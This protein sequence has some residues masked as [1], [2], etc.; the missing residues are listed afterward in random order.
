MDARAFRLDD[1]S[2]PYRPVHQTGPRGSRVSPTNSQQWSLAVLDRRSL[3]ISA[4]R[5]SAARRTRP[6]SGELEPALFE[7][8]EDRASAQ[9]LRGENVDDPRQK[10]Q[11]EAADNKMD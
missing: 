7:G 9:D 8:R 5:E 2:N 4:F 3:R 1:W 11:I 10:A 6:R